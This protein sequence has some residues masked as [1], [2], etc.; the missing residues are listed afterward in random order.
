MCRLILLD[1]QKG[2]F[3]KLKEIVIKKDKFSIL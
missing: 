3:F 1:G 2:T